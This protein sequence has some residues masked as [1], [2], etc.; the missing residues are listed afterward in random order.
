SGE[1]VVGHAVASIRSRDELAVHFEP[2][3]FL[4]GLLDAYR[5]RGEPMPLALALGG[6]PAR[7]LA[8]MASTPFPVDR[9][10]LAGLLRGRPLD[11]VRGRS[12][13]LEVPAEADFVVEGAI[14]PAA[15]PVETGPIFTPLAGM[16]A[17]RPAP[18][19]RV[20]ALTRR[21]NPVVPVILPETLASEWTVITR[22]MHR[23]LLPLTR[24]LIDELADCNLPEFGM[25]RTMA[26]VSIRKKDDQIARRVA[27]ALWDLPGTRFCS[28]MV[29]VDEDVD[30]DDGRQIW[31]AKGRN[32]DGGRDVFMEAGPPDPWANGKAAGQPCQRLA[33]DA[34]SKQGR[35]RPIHYSSSSLSEY[36][37]NLKTKAR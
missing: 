20:A 25:G 13:D 19:L 26:W 32:I 33:F 31:A 24:L 37:S 17:S 27:R 10:C 8:A 21:A 4:A 16:A 18:I 15:V 2:L 3:D 29:L 30:V 1:P 35:N 9:D 5:R 14:D 36:N 23:V 12:V 7:L 11:N 28:L 6:H 22:T 34:T